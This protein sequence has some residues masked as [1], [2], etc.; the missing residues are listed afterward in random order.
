MSLLNSGRVIRRLRA[1]L[2][3]SALP[4]ANRQALRTL[5]RQALPRHWSIYV[6]PLGYK[7]A[8]LNRVGQGVVQ[9]APA[10]AQSTQ[11]DVSELIKLVVGVARVGFTDAKKLVNASEA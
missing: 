6:L 3:V 9:E 5:E 2:S 10:M 1:I 11:S 4:R 7:A 8:L